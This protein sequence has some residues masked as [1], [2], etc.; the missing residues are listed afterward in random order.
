MYTIN[1]YATDGYPLTPK[2]NR[3]FAVTIVHNPGPQ[4]NETIA[5][6]V[7]HANRTSNVT[8]TEFQFTW[9]EGTPRVVTYEIS[10]PTPL[11]AY[12]MNTRVITANVGPTD[13]G[14]FTFTLTASDENPN[15]ANATSSF[16]IGKL[17]YLLIGF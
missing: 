1:L 2:P 15:T 8:L 7:F 16:N 11:L 12:D 6:V 4:V 13:S 10:P 3:T 5:N 17:N 14:N 9:V